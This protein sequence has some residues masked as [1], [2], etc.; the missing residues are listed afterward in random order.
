[1]DLA[2]LFDR[3]Q[4]PQSGDLAIDGDSDQWADLIAGTEPGLDAGVGRL[5]VADH[6]ADSLPRHCD[7]RC[8][9]GEI[10]HLGWN[11]HH[12]HG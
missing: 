2:V 1:V 9:A 10:T 8:A 3:L 11:P 5:Q 4:H 7:P 6:L 12:R